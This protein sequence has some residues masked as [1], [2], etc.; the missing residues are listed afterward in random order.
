MIIF[1][2]KSAVFMSNNGKDTK[3]IRHISRRMH[4]YV[5]MKSAKYIILTGMRDV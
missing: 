3:H 5:M 2:S 1:D 4:F